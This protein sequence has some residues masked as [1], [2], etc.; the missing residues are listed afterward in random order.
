MGF[1]SSKAVLQA[2]HPVEHLPAARPT[3]R[4]VA[5]IGNFPPRRC[6]I[7]TFTHDTWQAL[8]TELPAAAW[9]V[10]AMEDRDQPHPYPPEVTDIVR[11]ADPAA[12]DRLGHA[13][14]RWEADIVFLQH[15]FGI[16]GG[17]DGQHILRTLRRLRM[18]VV[19][20]LH[21]V[22][23]QPTPG[24]KR[25][26]DEIISLS[27]SVI[28]MTEMGADILERVHHAG[29]TKVH[30]VPHGAPERPLSPT[31]PF[32]A[33][34]GLADD[35]VIMTFGLLSPNK[36]IETV[37]RALP[38]VLRTTPNARYLIVGATHP[39]LVAREGETY[40]DSL[41]KLAT[42]LGVESHL[43]FIDRFVDDTELA[44]LL[45]AADVYVTPYLTEAQVTSG[46]LS[47]AVALGKPVVSTPYWHARELLADG[48]GALCPFG[49]S[50][51]F[52]REIGALLEDD[53]RR[54]MAAKRA[55]R[56]GEP[57]RW[58]KVASSILDIASVARADHRRRRETRLQVLAHPRLD[59]LM[60]MSDDCGILQHS[61]FGVPDR[62]HG[63][64]TDDNARLLALLAVLSSE[65]ALSPAAEKLMRSAAAFVGHAWNAQEGRFRNF[66]SFD[67]QWLDA[68]GSND[69]SARAFEAICIVSAHARQEDIRAWAISLVHQ[70]IP[71]LAGW[72][73]LRA[74]ALIV[75]GLIE[76]AKAAIPAEE[77]ERLMRPHAD[78]LCGAATTGSR[79]PYCWFEP[80]FT[81]DNGNLPCA[82]IRAGDWLQDASML[83]VGLDMFERLMKQQTAP[84]GGFCPV[85]TS[86]FDLGS[87]HEH[88]DQQPLEAVATI[89][90][91][92]AA[93]AATGD[94]IHALTAQRVFRWF[95]GDNMHGVA[96]ARPEDGICHDGLTA[97]GLNMNHGAESIISYHLAAAA[98]RRLVLRRSVGLV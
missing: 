57:S 35:K 22:L 53:A 67:R 76:A 72:N 71:A 31:Q 5:M 74:H 4:R 56:A 69:C 25:V 3:L 15:E 66:M 1:D 60:L 2:L 23:K 21:T 32:K 52:A 26:L 59:G 80:C 7:A 30:V 18:P 42:S 89:D 38:S 93:W 49:D 94:S 24:Q 33:P 96:L 9:R 65:S 17:D 29:A 98:M 44:D 77:A 61:R 16:F 81:Y 27:A 62:A 19:T 48:V 39:H 58:R 45:Q 37:I 8:R 73:S 41:V 82:L 43:R 90:A 95:G 36:G 70:T 6:G 85:A 11:A 86:R 34:L 47:F 46:T 91:A 78:A 54:D 13:L 55:Y 64:C 79:E 92:L 28:V 14:N 84:D 51:A 97:Q 10:A 75:R 87:D 88:Y 12:F 40:R 20:T 63:Y 68:G 50:A 83:G